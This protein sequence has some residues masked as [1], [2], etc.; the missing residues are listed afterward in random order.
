MAAR[1]AQQQEDLKGT[2]ITLP[3]P[4]PLKL[5]DDL[6]DDDAPAAGVLRAALA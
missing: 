2:G 1:H 6:A 4:A 5:A 3:P